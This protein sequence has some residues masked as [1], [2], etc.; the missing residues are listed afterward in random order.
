MKHFSKVTHGFVSA[1]QAPVVLETIKENW[2]TTD[3]E[4]IN[5]TGS[6]GDLWIHQLP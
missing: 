2:A 3:T 4:I 6:K 1:R 5:E